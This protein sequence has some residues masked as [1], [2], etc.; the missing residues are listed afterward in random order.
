MVKL[1]FPNLAEAPNSN[2]GNE[3]AE[4]TTMLG[5]A[6]DSKKRGRYNMRWIE[7][8]REAVALSLQ[9]LTKVVNDRIY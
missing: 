1:L 2:W 4:K 6:G 5:K 7:S 8:I 3:P 9:Y